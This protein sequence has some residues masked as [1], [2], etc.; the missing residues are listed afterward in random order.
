M[1]KVKRV[2]ALI[3]C[4][5]KRGLPN[6]GIRNPAQ[7]EPEP[8]STAGRRRVYEEARKE[9]LRNRFDCNMGPGL[10]LSWP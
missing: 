7:P 9:S 10:V 4:A 8:F 2:K 1:E 3:Q 6:L 5:L